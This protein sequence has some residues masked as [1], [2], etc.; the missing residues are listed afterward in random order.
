MHISSYEYPTPL[1]IALL[2][3][4]HNRPF[5]DTISCVKELHPDI[6]AVAG[7]LILGHRFYGNIPIVEKQENVIPFLK[8]CAAVSPTFFSYGNH[9]WQLNDIDVSAIRSTGAV[10]LDN[11][12]VSYRGVCIGGFT[13]ARRTAY[14]SLD[15][16]TSSNGEMYPDIHIPDNVKE[17]TVPDTSWLGNFELQPGYKILLCHHPEYRDLYLKDRKI[18]LILSGHCHGGQIRLFGHGL[19]SPG[20][21]IF[22]KYTN[23]V[24]GNMIVSAGLANTAG[25]I[26]RLFN[27]REIVYISSGH[28]FIKI[29]KRKG[30]F[31]EGRQRMA[32]ECSE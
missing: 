11:D 9:E 3:D 21:G 7:D 12:Y 27:P 4:L 25:I 14:S 22:P 17:K 19:F 13:S 30:V 8:A 20:Q 15:I 23:G 1:S 16:P 10:I 6:I 24:Y 5:E 26:P 31:T 18:D 28:S 29:E 32:F 2:T